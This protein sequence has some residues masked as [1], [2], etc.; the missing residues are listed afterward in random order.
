MAM[1]LENTLNFIKKWKTQPFPADYY[2]DI[3]RKSHDLAEAQ[4]QPA[5]EVFIEGLDD[6]D[7]LWRHDCVT[8]L[9]FHYPLENEV[10]EKIRDLLLNDPSSDVRI[11]AASAL[12]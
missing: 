5:K 12:G 1:E 7:W 4:Y 6:P 8:F 3:W 10:V 11:A 9:G 2:D